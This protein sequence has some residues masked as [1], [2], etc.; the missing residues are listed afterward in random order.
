[1]QTKLWLAIGLLFVVAGCAARKDADSVLSGALEKIG[2]VSSIEYSGT[3]R[4]GFFGQAILAGQEWPLRE[5]SSF[6]R[7]IDYTQ[8]SAREELT[9]TQPTFGG[10]QQNAQVNGDKAWNMGP[11]GP[12]PQAAAAE[13]RQLLIWLTPHG[14]LKGAHDAG[15]ATLTESA[16]NDV[17]SFTAL[18][19]YPVRG[20]IDAQGL[21]TQVATA[22]P[23]P[24]LGDTAVV[25]TYSGYRAFDGVQFPARIV[26]TQ[27][28]SPVWQLDITNVR[29][30]APLDLPVPEAV[31]S[32]AAAP[33]PPAVS[34]EL[35]DGVWFVGGRGSRCATC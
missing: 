11:N 9:F 6:T 23:T 5:M 22:I 1:M 29:P 17:V 2:D 24:V 14:F 13:E 8:R 4:N 30:N 21:V 19:K 10:Q 27:G 16:G 31:A 33:P 12:V 35:A 7:T 26:V 28:D 25:A 34:S 18:G 3:G 15:N 32:A 20:T